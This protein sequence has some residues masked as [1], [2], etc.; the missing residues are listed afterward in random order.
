MPKRDVYIE[1]MKSQLDELN[2]HIAELEEKAK[3]VKDHTHSTYETQINKMKP[4]AEAITSTLHQVKSA[5][6]DRLTHLAEESDK[7][8]KAFL[9]SYHYF[10]S[11]IK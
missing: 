2:V 9:H 6:E 3:R 1:K 10:K 5:G 4:M 7:V 11:Q 8:Y